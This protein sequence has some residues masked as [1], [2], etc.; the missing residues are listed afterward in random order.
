MIS[1]INKIQEQ[2]PVA[3]PITS[4]CSLVTEDDTA[5]TLSNED[6]TNNSKQMLQ[7]YDLLEGSLTGFTLYSISPYQYD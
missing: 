7:S 6:H 1:D 3:K 4:D 5:T 2:E